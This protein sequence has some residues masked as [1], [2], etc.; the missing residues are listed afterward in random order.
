MLDQPVYPHC[1]PPHAPP[2][3]VVFQSANGEDVSLSD[4]P[5]DGGWGRGETSGLMERGG[6]EGRRGNFPP[7]KYANLCM[8]HTFK[9]LTK[10]FYS[11]A[12]VSLW[13]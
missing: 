10:C 2:G 8:F 12:A 1:C 13:I 4:L 6:D 3:S 5:W 7:T 11:V 9:I